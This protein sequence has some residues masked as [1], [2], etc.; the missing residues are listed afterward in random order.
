MSTKTMS[1]DSR[2]D[3]DILCYIWN[4]RMIKWFFLIWKIMAVKEAEEPHG[5]KFTMVPG[6]KSRY[7]RNED[8]FMAC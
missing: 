7:A 2:K 8:T 3:T 6:S 5:M 1:L 4:G